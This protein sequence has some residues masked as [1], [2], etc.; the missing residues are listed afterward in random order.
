VAG[1]ASPVQRVSEQA[2]N[3]AHTTSMMIALGL[4]GL[5]CFIWLDYIHIW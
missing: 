4:T 5:I 2:A 3:N 1:R